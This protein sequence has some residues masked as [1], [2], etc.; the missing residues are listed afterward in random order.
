MLI[1]IKVSI[2]FFCLLGSIKKSF[3]SSS[4]VVPY[5]FYDS[6]FPQEC[7]EF[8]DG[9]LE[10]LYEN[11]KGARLIISIESKVQD[12]KLRIKPGAS[13]CFCYTNFSLEINI[14]KIQ[15]MLAAG[16]Y[17]VFAE[18][19]G[20]EVE[21]DVN[22]NLEKFYECGKTLYPFYFVL[23]HELI[24]VLHFLNKPEK[25]VKILTKVDNR[26]WRIYEEQD[27]SRRNALWRS[28][29]EQRAV[30]G[31]PRV[32][33]LDGISEM[34]LLLS[35]NR[36]PRYA[37][38]GS[39][40]HFYERSSIIRQVLLND[41]S[42]IEMLNN[43]EIMKNIEFDQGTALNSLYNPE[44][45]RTSSRSSSISS[46]VIPEQEDSTAQAKHRAFLRK[47]EKKSQ[48]MPEN[49]KK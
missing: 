25:Y 6:S 32:N 38:Q 8:I 30:I 14:E 39:T 43:L 28:L 35:Q 27:N 41:E 11:P 45:I 2:V 34:T 37:Y 3:A 15:D 17:E 5:I 49:D 1:M 40:A 42:W 26:L 44:E 31:F 46:W 21:K 36:R 10:K 22:E 24:H 12:R 47:K 20:C 19:L 23:G 18:S 16:D 29:E 48:K 4:N 9:Q 7:L 13:H 33:L